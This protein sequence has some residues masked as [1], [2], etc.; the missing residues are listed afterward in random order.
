MLDGGVEELI[1]I[2]RH[3]SHRNRRTAKRKIF[4]KLCRVVFKTGI[5]CA[6]KTGQGLEDGTM[7]QDDGFGLRMGTV[8]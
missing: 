4:L 7:E 8:A 1:V 2:E 6:N 3:A 5:L